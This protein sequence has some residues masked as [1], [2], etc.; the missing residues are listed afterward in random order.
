[1][2][3]KHR[4]QSQVTKS[5]FRKSLLL[6]PVIGALIKLIIILRIDAIAWPGVDPSLYRLDK[7][8]LGAD[9]ENYITGLTG[10][11]A[12]GIFSDVERL[13]YFPAGYPILIYLVGFWSQA[14]SLF[15]TAVLQTLIYAAASAYFVD[16][17]LMTKLRR[18]VIPL[19]LILALN[20]TLSLS[21]YAIGYESLIAS[22]V[23]YIVALLIN[24]FLKVNSGFISREV[25]LV[26]SLFS[27][28]SFIQPRMVATAFVVFVVWALATR[29]RLN[30]VL[31]LITAMTIT[32]LLPATLY[33]RNVVA[34]DV[35]A[36]STNLGT[37]MF[38][39][40][41]PG[42]TGG[43]NGQ[44]NG[45]PCPQAVGTEA[46][47]DNAKV[48]C[49]IEWYVTNPL[50]TLELSAKKALYYWSPWFGP[51]ANGTMARNP[52]NQNHP[53]KSTVQTQEGFDL[54][55]GTTGKVLSWLWVA[56]TLVFMLL[57][58]LVLWRIN[59][60]ERLLGIVSLG[61]VVINM[62]VSMATIGDHRFR[63]PAAGLSLLLQVVGLTWALSKRKRRSFGS[64]NKLLWKSFSRTTNLPT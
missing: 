25:I 8:W 19:A 59:G 29:N 63:L 54:I 18:F 12:D 37:T 24:D 5:N 28:A 20:P 30:A 4:S 16:R 2:A 45:V 55:Y 41:G 17:L 38:I 15:T 50:K 44:Y 31:M 9:G 56:G 47:I 7:Y 61:I 52:W 6:I 10:L 3:K 14:W 11:F 53:L 51:V 62:L 34:R 43:Y 33:A 49:A 22:L 60:V 58:F 13:T 1:M 48:R 42:A 39:G 57:G 46:Q 26:A 21:T 32:L 40:I 27:L 36:I 64:E 35:P 23:L